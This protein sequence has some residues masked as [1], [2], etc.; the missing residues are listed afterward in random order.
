MDMSKLSIDNKLNCILSTGPQLSAVSY[1]RSK[2]LFELPIAYS[3]MH[4]VPIKPKIDQK[5][6]PKNRQQKTPR[7]R[8]HNV[9]SLN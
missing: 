1:S 6:T 5:Y 8:H 4:F 7:K 3:K 2:I 9:N